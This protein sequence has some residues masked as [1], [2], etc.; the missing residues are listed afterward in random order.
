M[1][2]KDV[3]IGMKVKV[4][5]IT[6]TESSLTFLEIF[7]ENPT[8]ERVTYRVK[9]YSSHD[10]CWVL[11]RTTSGMGM[12]YVMAKDFEPYIEEGE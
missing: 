4:H 9:C 6:W 2:S 1:R 10:K 5:D 12:L 7:G 8:A 11:S 3:V